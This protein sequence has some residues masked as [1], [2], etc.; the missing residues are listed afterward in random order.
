MALQ[1]RE[2]DVLPVEAL[3]TILCIP[4]Q[5]WLLP[6]LDLPDPISALLGSV[7]KLFPGYLSLLPLPVHFLLAL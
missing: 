5:V 7:P 6:C 4:C 3:L 2:K 1:F